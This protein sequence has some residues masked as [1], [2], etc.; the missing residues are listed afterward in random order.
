MLCSLP[1]R[2]TATT[3]LVVG[4]DVRDLTRKP[5]VARVWHHQLHA[6]SQIIQREHRFNR[7]NQLS[8]A[9]VSSGEVNDY[10]TPATPPSRR[11]SAQRSWHRNRY[12]PNTNAADRYPAIVELSK[13][14]DP[15]QTLVKAI[16]HKVARNLCQVVA[17][18][19]VTELVMPSST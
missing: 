17:S 3:F 1:Y 13:Q 15:M 19:F 16:G 10:A 8:L 9:T 11:C 5:M 18:V 7:I 4:L 2:V 14:G 6:G 12:V